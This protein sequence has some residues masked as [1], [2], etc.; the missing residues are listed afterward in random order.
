MFA[1]ADMARRLG[2]RL[3]AQV[4]HKLGGKPSVAMLR[5]ADDTFDAA[6]KAQYRSFLSSKIGEPV[7]TPHRRA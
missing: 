6:T 7:P 5:Y 4:Y 3:E 2:K 1:A